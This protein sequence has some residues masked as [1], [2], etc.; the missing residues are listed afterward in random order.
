MLFLSCCVAPFTRQI[1]RYIGMYMGSSKFMRLLT[2]TERRTLLVLLL[3]LL[4]IRSLSQHAD[5]WLALWSHHHLNS[6]LN[7]FPVR[8]RELAERKRDGFYPWRTGEYK[9]GD[10]WAYVISNICWWK[11]LM[12]TKRRDL[13]W[14]KS[15]LCLMCVLRLFSVFGSQMAQNTSEI[16][17]NDMSNEKNERQSKKSRRRYDFLITC[18]I[19]LKFRW[20]WSW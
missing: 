5:Y 3:L 12:K 10:K 6:N 7:R 13:E 19:S 20:N 9:P 4:L 1:H 18:I 15:T 14:K 8:S 17:R 16:N 2:Q 11:T